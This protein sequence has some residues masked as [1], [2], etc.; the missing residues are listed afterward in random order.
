MVER[1]EILENM[2]LEDMQEHAQD[3]HYHG[4][5]NGEVIT[6]L[7]DMVKEVYDAHSGDECKLSAGDAIF[8]FVA[9]ITTRKEVV[10]AGS[11]ELYIPWV[12]LIKQFTESNNIA[13]PKDGWEK[14]LVHPK[15]AG[16]S[17]G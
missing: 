3:R 1:N 9:W 5:T 16:E 7:V 15:E 4:A 11:S 12:D 2:T 10:S 13:N 8:G 17:D 6:R 14:N